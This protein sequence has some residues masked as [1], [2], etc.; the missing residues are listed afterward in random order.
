MTKQANEELL[1]ALLCRRRSLHT[2]GYLLYRIVFVSR[3]TGIP[4]TA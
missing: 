1:H 4:T 3:N 2:A